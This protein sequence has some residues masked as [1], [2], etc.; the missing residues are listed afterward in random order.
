MDSMDKFGWIVLSLA[1][2]MMF[3]QI[4]RFVFNYLWG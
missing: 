4:V 2:L 1:G 3:A